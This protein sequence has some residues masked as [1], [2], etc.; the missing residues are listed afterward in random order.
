MKEPSGIWKSFWNNAGLDDGAHAQV[1]LHYPADFEVPGILQMIERSEGEEA[2]ETLQ[3]GRFA[4]VFDWVA[5]PLGFVNKD[6][7][8]YGADER[9]LKERMPAMESW[10]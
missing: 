7:F 3:E 10:Y 9:R 2:L 6:K 5:P 8:F 1:L 4:E